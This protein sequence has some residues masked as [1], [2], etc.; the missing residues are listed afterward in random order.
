MDANE[1]DESGSELLKDVKYARKGDAED[2]K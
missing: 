2:D 1:R